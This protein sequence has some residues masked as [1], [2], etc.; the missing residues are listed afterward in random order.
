MVDV[1]TPSEVDRTLGILGI[2]PGPSYSRVLSLSMAKVV[3]PARGPCLSCPSFY[4]LSL[5]DYFTL[6]RKFLASTYV[7]SLLLVL[8]HCYKVCF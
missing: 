6:P 4:G 8:L 2:H 1:V 7:T 5:N 3:G